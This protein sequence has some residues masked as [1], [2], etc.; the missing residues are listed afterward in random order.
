MP[1][2]KKQ[3]ST[4]GDS[5]SGPEDVSFIEKFFFIN[6]NLFFSALRLRNLKILK[7]GD[8]GKNTT[9]VLDK[10][11]HVRINEFKGRKLIDIREYYEKDGKTLPGKKG[12]SLSITQWKNLLEVAK[13]ITE[14]I[15]EN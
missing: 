14:A 8:G 2:T 7:S 13:E 9:W 4:S 12:I 11:R 3:D 10:Q 1:K 15:G 5:D 6:I